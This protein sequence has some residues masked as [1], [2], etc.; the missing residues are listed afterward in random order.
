MSGTGGRGSRGEV[1]RLTLSGVLLGV[2]LVLGFVEHSLPSLAVPGI[3]LGLSNSVL[4]FAAYMLDLPT[5]WCLMALKVTLS[6]FLFSGPIAMMYAFAGGTLSMLVMTLLSR[7]PRLPVTAVS[8]A[9][10]VAH[11]VGQVALA[12][13]IAHLPT[14]LLLGVYLAILVGSGAVCGALTGTA[15][16]LVM[17]HLGRSFR[18][19]KRTD[20]N[21]RTIILIAIVLVLAAGLISW[22][23]LPKVSHET[24]EITYSAP[25]DP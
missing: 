14:Q 2:M 3:K 8:V 22:L 15:A 6:G 1:Q 12:V 11:N 23:S 21:R 10:G 20:A 4:I 18:I 25:A 24:V 13:V 19:P 5:A 16:A 17:K 9:G 7:I